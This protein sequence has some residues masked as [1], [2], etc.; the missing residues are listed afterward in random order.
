MQHQN[1]IVNPSF[2]QIN[3]LF[4]NKNCSSVQIFGDLKTE[5]DK[6]NLERELTIFGLSLRGKVKNH[7]YY[8][9]IQAQQWQLI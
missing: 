2:V 9:I 8:P 5:R 3:K 7:K 1:L 6:E 4:N